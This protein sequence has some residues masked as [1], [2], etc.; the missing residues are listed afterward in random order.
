MKKL[1]LGLVLVF[2]AGGAYMYTQKSKPSQE[3][4]IQLTQ[5]QTQTPPDDQ[6]FKG[7]LAAAVSLG[8]PMKCS[9]SA[10]GTTGEG[11]IQGKNYRGTMTT[12]DGIVTEVIMKDSC[13]WSW[14][15]KGQGMTMC[16]EPSE[17]QTK[18]W[19]DMAKDAPSDSPA[20][21]DSP[22]TP[23]LNAEYDCKPTLISDSQFEPPTTVQ[24]TDLSQV[25]KPGA[26]PD[27]SKLKEMMGE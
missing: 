20:S 13:M 9:F 2:L 10:N 17:A 4:Q 25:M 3:T 22:Q 15:D 23:E 27:M 11:Y 18:L 7:T 12:K 26:L 1:L 8:V 5:E 14:S 24:F 6:A 16:Y 21:Q 19:Q